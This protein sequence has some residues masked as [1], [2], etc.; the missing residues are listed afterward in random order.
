MKMGPP[1]KPIFWLHGEIKSPPFSKD[2][3]VQAGFLLRM[4]QE[5]ESLQMPWSRTMPSMGPRC[6]ELRIDDR[7]RTWRIIYRADADAII[8]GEVFEKKTPKTPKHV[9]DICR[10]RFRDYDS[11]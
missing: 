2:A 5:G 9:I 4:L 1:E 11:A 7:G 6:H 10:R 8:I 3:R